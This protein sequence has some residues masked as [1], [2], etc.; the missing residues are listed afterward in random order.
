MLVLLQDHDHF[1]Q[2]SVAGS[3]AKTIHS[4]LDLA[5][6]IHDAS[7]GVSC[8]KTE[9]IVAM[10]GKYCLINITYIVDKESDLLTILLWQAITRSIRDIYSGCSRCDHCFNNTGE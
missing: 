1:F 6:T 4:A 9:I 3:F 5:C 7:N 10:T 2:R 8:G